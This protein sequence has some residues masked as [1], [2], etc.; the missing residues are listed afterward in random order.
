M[1]TESER[2]SVQTYVSSD[3]RALW[4]EEAEELDMSQAEYVRTM[5]QAGRRG[6]ELDVDGT[7]T[8]PETNN[9]VEQA[10]TNA[11][12][13]VDGLKDQVLEIVRE[14]EYPDWDGL[15]AGVTGDI[16]DRLEAVLDELK[17]EGQI[18]YKDRHGGYVM[19]NN[20]S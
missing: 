3:Q 13:G 6:F 18:Q 5:V 4:R 15:L 11:T 9:P 17:T 10:S 2:V 1:A 14:E 12:P 7:A 8:R 16:E 19:T 20:G